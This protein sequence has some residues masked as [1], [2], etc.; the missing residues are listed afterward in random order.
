MYK[1]FVGFIFFSFFATATVPV[2]SELD[3][4][5]DS[6]HQA[7]G[8]ANEEKYLGLLAEDAIFLGTD[9]AER[10][11]KSEFSAFVK[12][13][14]SQGQGWLYQPI[15]RHITPTQARNIFFFDE[16]LENKSYGRCRGSGLLINTENGWKILQYNLSIPVPNAIALQVVA[17]I[18]G[19]RAATIKK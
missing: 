12:P 3:A 15:K 17:S 9:S 1:V 5:L 18:K 16:L 10:W 14:F 11:N 4:V 7:A 8:E 2:N 13:Y 19:Y 6:F